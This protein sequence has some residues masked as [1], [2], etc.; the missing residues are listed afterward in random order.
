MN[1]Q[2]KTIAQSALATLLSES[3]GF[4]LNELDPNTSFPEL[5]FDS[6]F[7]VQF[8]QNVKSRLKI[9]LT[10]RQLLEEVP[11]IAALT[12]YVAQHLSESQLQALGGAAVPPTA[13][14]APTNG[15][16]TG[17]EARPVPSVVINPEPAVVD[18]APAISSQPSQPSNAPS[19]LVSTAIQQPAA[20]ANAAQEFGLPTLSDR[21]SATAP[22]IL[23]PPAPL[24]D[25][26]SHSSG[27]GYSKEGLAEIIAQQNQLMSLQLQLLA[28]AIPAQANANSQA[29]G[30]PRQT[31]PPELQCASENSICQVHENG[32][33][34]LSSDP[35]FSSVT[36]SQAATATPRGS[37][38]EANTVTIKRAYER[39][40]PF[41]PVR[42][43]LGGG[44]TERQQQY[45]D[46]LIDRFT[47]KTAKSRDHA[48]RHRDHFADPRGVAGYRRIWKSM[49]Y[50]I[51]V[52]HSLGSKLWDIDGNEYID[53]AMGFGLN[54]FGQSPPF[55]TEALHRQLDKGVEVG[56]QSPLAGEVA[57]L[58]CDF[59]R[60]ERATF[61][62]T[63]SEAVMAAMRLARTVTGKTKIVFFNKDYHGN[64]DQVLVR[65]T[66][67]GQQRRSQPAAPG[68]PQGLAD[69]AIILDYGT[70][71][72]LRVLQERAD[73]IA[74]V[75]VE[76]VQSA[77]PF[78]QPREFLHQVR[79]ITQEN[80]IALVMD[81]V[82]TGFRAAQGG[83]QEWF[84]VWG[85]MATYGKILGGGLPIGALTG[86]RRFMDALDGGDWKYD[87]HSEPEA[88]MTFFAGTFVRHPLAMTA[89]HQILMKI[90]EEGPELQQQLTT[91]TADLANDLNQFFETELFPIRVAQFTSLFRFMFPPTVEYADLLYFHLLD[92]GIFTRGW[93]DNCFLSTAHTEQDIEKIIRAVKDSCHEIREGGFMPRPDDEEEPGGTKKPL[94]F[95]SNLPDAS[96]SQELKAAACESPSAQPVPANATQSNGASPVSNG[97]RP[98]F[99]LSTLEEIRGHGT[100]T[101]LFC[102][103]AADGLTLVFHELAERLGEDQP[104][105]GLNSPGAYGEQVP[106][107]MEQMA[108]R[109]I[110]DIREE[111]PHGPYAL[112]GYCSGGTIAFEAAQQLVTQGE[113]VI[114]LAGIETYDWGTAQSSKPTMWTRF[115]YSLQRFEFH[116]R[117][118]FL[119]NW[120]LKK[121]YLR[122]KWGRLKS[123]TAIWK[124]MFLSL[125]SKHRGTQRA[126][127]SQVNWNEVWRAHDAQADRYVKKPYPGK[128]LMIRPRKDFTSY[129]GKE[130]LAANQ[131][132]EYVRM[133]AFPTGLMSAPFVDQL[134]ALV[135]EKLEQA[136]QSRLHTSAT[137]RVFEQPGCTA[138][139]VS[140]DGANAPQIAENGSLVPAQS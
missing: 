45:L 83:A 76:P 80:D 125:F 129:L 52:G 33:T 25:G 15:N 140:Y 91:K 67:I 38:A 26:Y 90:K 72:A 79:R 54:L 136:E 132:V 119:L 16:S 53:I 49:V 113:E 9:K 35:T 57:Q 81:E 73:E 135:R 10:F 96:S 8:T 37:G 126:N 131:G 18:E 64:F 78:L 39:F 101:P 120:A 32:G 115:Y 27:P 82:I 61:C 5:G 24:S 11:N 98:V 95:A 56:P 6:L 107:T 94:A 86:S 128:M 99:R 117:N 4:N 106:Y 28:G 130:E 30:Y 123:R 55:V 88:D 139:S 63:G 85:D 17:R 34:A 121:E 104:V 124:G 14:S 87:D 20:P 77:D 50:Q 133:D 23:S 7:L 103:P 127:A 122:S 112:I 138:N 62:N 137:A 46:R 22:M 43:A 68:V 41:K 74:A 118:F 97:T 134:A 19:A 75:L 109:F 58:L 42:K 60:K 92:R 48:Q 21:P 84:D 59:A 29:S 110:E 65:S 47:S 93:G 3:S 1:S 51:S 89:A 36:P 71:E 111:F 108:A 2:R 102:M 100:R 13:S 12:D 116:L 105:Y 70:D 44:L 40:G 66:V 31:P 69:Q 114:F